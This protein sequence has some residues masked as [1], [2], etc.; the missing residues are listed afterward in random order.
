MPQDTLDHLH[1]LLNYAWDSK[2]LLSLILIGSP[3]LNERLTMRRNRSLHSR[4]TYR[5]AIEPLADTIVAN[6]GFRDELMRLIRPGQ[7]SEPS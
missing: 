7:R 1:I 6:P 3:D 2:A 5:L 4:I